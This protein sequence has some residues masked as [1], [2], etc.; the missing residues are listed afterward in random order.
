[1]PLDYMGRQTTTFTA[2]ANAPVDLNAGKPD[3]RELGPLFGVMLLTL[4][5]VAIGG[6]LMIFAWPRTDSDM[7]GWSILGIGTGALFMYGGGSVFWTLR[8]AMVH[9]IRGHHLRLDDWHNAVLD[10]YIEGDG[11]VQIQ[12]VTEWHLVT[13]E[14]RHMLLL[15]L[16]IYLNNSA[17]SIN[18]LTAGPLLV[19]AGHRAFSLGKVSQDQAS[20]AL[21][22]MARAG[23]LIDRRTGYNGKLAVM[24][25]KQA[26]NKVL[27]QMAADPRIV[28]AER[29]E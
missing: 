20:D 5:P 12:Q 13:T 9:G 19:K 27:L 29:T 28:D 16:Y 18:K 21:N 1:M 17:P 24:D 11:A 6:A 25:F 23:V 3:W 2:P 8:H 14:P 15:L 4:L 22:L 7:S 26:A 10:K